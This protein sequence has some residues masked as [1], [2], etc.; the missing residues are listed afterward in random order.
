MT[1]NLISGPIL[2]QILAPEIFFV[3]FI[4]TSS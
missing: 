4:S 1:K 3:Y 2:A